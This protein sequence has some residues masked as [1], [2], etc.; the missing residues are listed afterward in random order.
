M[1]VR[2][3]IFQFQQQ[4]G[5]SKVC[6]AHAVIGGR[7]ERCADLLL[8]VLDEGR[9]TPPAGQPVNFRNTIIIATSNIGAQES[10]R[11][12]IGFGGR[13][14]QEEGDNRMREALEAAFRPEFLNRFQH[15]VPFHA[16][17]RD[18][19]IL[20]RTDNVVDKDARN[21]SDLDIVPRAL[22]TLL[23]ECLPV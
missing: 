23:P 5:G 6:R 9:L 13:R 16:L 3:N 15:V 2:E 19:V 17:T 8:Q 7:L 4:I 11:P 22:E 12:N 1:A 20:M 18:Q 14:S 21:F 10:A